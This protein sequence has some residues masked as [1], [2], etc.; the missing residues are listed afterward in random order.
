MFLR[1]GF[2]IIGDMLITGI[3]FSG[4]GYEGIPVF[5]NPGLTPRPG[6]AITAF[7]RRKEE[8]VGLAH[9]ILSH[10]VDTVHCM[11]DVP[12]QGPT[13]VRIVQDAMNVLL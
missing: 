5:A 3:V 9:G 4:P 6:R 10:M 2:F 11:A 12:R 8:V 7:W 13:M 1:E